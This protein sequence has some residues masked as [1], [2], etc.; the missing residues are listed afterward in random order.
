MEEITQQIK[1]R[2]WQLICPVIR[3]NAPWR[4]DLEEEGLGKL[5]D[6]LW[7]WKEES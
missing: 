6:G 4:E 7:R 5:G 1:Q 2:H 3:K